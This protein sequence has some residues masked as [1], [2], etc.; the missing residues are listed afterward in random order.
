MLVVRARTEAMQP[1]RRASAPSP[2]FCAA[3]FFRRKPH[4]I[5]SLNRRLVRRGV[6]HFWKSR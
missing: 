5:G 4:S 6:A 1:I 2:P 3:F